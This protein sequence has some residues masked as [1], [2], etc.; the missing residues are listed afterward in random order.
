VVY[1]VHRDRSRRRA[2]AVAVRVRHDPSFCI[3]TAFFCYRR[4]TV[5]LRCRVVGRR[6]HPTTL[7]TLAISAV[8]LSRTALARSTTLIRSAVPALT[9]SV[10]VSCPGRP[11]KATA[12]ECS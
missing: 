12:I 3:L 10:R 1:S 9:D 11:G 7:P 2:A 5:T 8:R 4:P 6:F